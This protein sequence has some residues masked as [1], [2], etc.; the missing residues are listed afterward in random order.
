MKLMVLRDEQRTN[1]GILAVQEETSL[2]AYRTLALEQQAKI[3]ALEAQLADIT[4]RAARIGE[5]ALA[6]LKEL[7]AVSLERSRYRAALWTVARAE[8]LETAR[9][10]ARG[11]V[12]S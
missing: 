6:T 8:D 12:K 3:L 2:A 7:E 1:S 9:E 11:A 4:D 10:V 5:T